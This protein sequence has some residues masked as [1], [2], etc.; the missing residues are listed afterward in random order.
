MMQM[1]WPQDHS[2]FTLIPIYRVIPLGRLVHPHIGWRILKI[3]HRE[4]F[5]KMFVKE[6]TFVRK[7][8]MM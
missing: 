4:G 2:K 7:L 5:R 8:D 6:A 1:K 3:I